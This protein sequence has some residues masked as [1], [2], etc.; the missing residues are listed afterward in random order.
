MMTMVLRQ[1]C[2]TC[3]LESELEGHL[4]HMITLQCCNSPIGQD[5]KAKCCVLVVVYYIIFDILLTQISL[6]TLTL[7]ISNNEKVYIF[8]FIII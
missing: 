2:I 4:P 6:L 3:P 5:L 8:D 1:M 7:V